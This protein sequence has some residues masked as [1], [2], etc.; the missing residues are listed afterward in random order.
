MTAG[1]TAWRRSRESAGDENRERER[2]K[3]RVAAGQALAARRPDG[4]A[5]A[6]GVEGGGNRSRKRKLLCSHCYYKSTMRHSLP[7][8]FQLLATATRRSQLLFQLHV[9][10]TIPSTTANTP[11]TTTHTRCAPRR[12]KEA[13]FKQ[14][15]SR[16]MENC[17]DRQR[18]Q[19][20]LREAGRG[21]GAAAAAVPLACR[22]GAVLRR[23]VRPLPRG[24]LCAQART[25]QGGSTGR[26]EGCPAAVPAATLCAVT[27]LPPCCVYCCH[28]GL[29]SIPPPSHHPDPLPPPHPSHSPLSHRLPL[30]AATAAAIAAAIATAAV[31]AAPNPN[32]YLNPN[33]NI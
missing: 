15:N 17:N 13:L 21:A 22:A 23:R 8:C 20:E 4:R 29:H 14:R 16:C 32:P 31:A 25:D 3:C 33:P 11:T 24:A 1:G 30:A 5:R 18:P 9:H 28:V 10:T 19:V 6:G 2:E 27:V 26:P 12:N 7:S